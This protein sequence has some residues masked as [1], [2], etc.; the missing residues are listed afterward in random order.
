MSS[1]L[2]ELATRTW[3]GRTSV[4]LQQ[5]SSW[6]FTYV[7]V[8]LLNGLAQSHISTI[9]CSKLSLL[10]RI[11]PGLKPGYENP[12]T[13]ILEGTLAVAETGV[14]AHGVP[15]WLDV[16]LG[17]KLNVHSYDF[18]I[19]RLDAL[20][21]PPLPPDASKDPYGI[22]TV[23]PQI[24]LA[25]FPRFLL[26][27]SVILTYGL[28]VTVGVLRD[29]TGLLALVLLCFFTSI[30]SLARR[31]RLAFR[32]P[33]WKP[34]SA[35][36]E[37]RHVVL[38]IGTRIVVIRTTKYL[39]EVILWGN[40]RE[41]PIFQSSTRAWL[42]F[43]SFF[44]YMAGLFLLANAT[45]ETQVAFATILA[46]ISLSLLHPEYTDFPRS[47]SIIPSF[48]IETHREFLPGCEDAASYKHDLRGEEAFP[49]FT[50]TLWYAIYATKSIRW[51]VRARCVP[52]NDK[53]LLWLDEAYKN[54]GD[55]NWPAVHEMERIMQGGDTRASAIVYGTRRSSEDKDEDENETVDQGRDRNDLITPVPVENW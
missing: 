17:S 49:S 14:V 50:R 18:Q 34:E 3:A 31:N 44:S 6:M 46:I 30:G 19:W 1:P 45:P 48:K 4:I 21:T 51:V 15:D 7:P 42:H 25:A 37:P 54:I 32:M 22:P 11:V 28:I 53:W 23:H 33:L 8:L 35:P 10:P 13:Y 24:Q 41:I 26:L 29:W 39:E 55:I 52:S 9:S 43:I 2:L 38:I 47:H 36:P 40:P 16:M 27:S 20:E 12:V 5:A